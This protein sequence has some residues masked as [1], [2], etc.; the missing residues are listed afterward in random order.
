MKRR[1]FIL[2]FCLLSLLLGGYA[3]WCGREF[4]VHPK[5]VR[6]PDIPDEAW[7]AIEG[8]FAEEGF[9]IPRFRWGR[10]GHLLMHPYESPPPAQTQRIGPEKIYAFHRGIS[11]LFRNTKL[12]HWESY[13]AIWEKF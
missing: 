1:K 7:A 11:F 13:G 4:F 5:I 8:H 6:A 2:L 12:N 10:Y 9:P 3:G